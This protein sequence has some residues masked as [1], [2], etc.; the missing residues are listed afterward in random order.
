MDPYYCHTTYY[1]HFHSLETVLSSHFLVIKLATFH[2]VRSY[3]FL[4][5]YLNIIKQQ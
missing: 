3:A 2:L 4:R 5:K 1:Y